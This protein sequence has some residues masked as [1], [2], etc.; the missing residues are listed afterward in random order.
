MTESGNTGAHA[1]ERIGEERGIGQLDGSAIQHDTWHA[2]T[3]SNRDATGKCSQGREEFRT[4]VRGTTI[5]SV[6]VVARSVRWA[7]VL[8]AFFSSVPVFLAQERGRESAVQGDVRTFYGRTGHRPVWVDAQG[9]P[10]DLAWK[11]LGRL[12][13]AADDGLVEDDYHPADLEREAGALSGAPSAITSA[14]FDV[15]LTTSVLRF[16]RDLHVGRVDPR[17]LGFHLDHPVELHDFPAILQS[18][19]AAG[20]FSTAV[21][22]LQPPFTQY[23]RLRE[24]LR[25]YRTSDAAKA[26]QIEL[27]MERLRWLPD[28]QGEQLIVVNIPMFHLWGWEPERSDGLAVIDMPAITGRA[29]ATKTPVFTSRITSVVLNPEWVVPDSIARNEI[30]PA[31]ATDPH[32]LARHHMEMS[33]EGGHVRIRQL[34]GPWNALGQIKFVFPNVHGVYLHGTPAPQLF[35]KARRDFSHGCIRVKDPL[36]LA[37]W[38]LGGQDGWTRQRMLD[39]IAQGA[40]RA[41]AMARQPRVVLFYM[42]AA[43][44]P[45]EGEVRFVDDIYGHDARLDAWLKAR[46]GSDK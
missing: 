26:K 30:L 7:F 41:L 27:A 39:V 34:P 9:R 11:A 23:R 6:E 37:E 40:T 13:H 29:G 33:R 46:T 42:T 31:I 21:T 24:A 14:G 5:A 12:R 18:V 44:M 32:Y 43:F 28:L 8:A 22:G 15:R 1:R 25:A 2:T 16:F 17:S 36:A 35:E 4:Y 20:S 19:L 10:T 45:Q 3:A 38:L